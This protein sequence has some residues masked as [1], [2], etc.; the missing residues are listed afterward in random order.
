VASSTAGVLMIVGSALFFAG[1]AIA[2]PRVFTE[3]DRAEKA[4]LLAER[5]TAWRVGQPLYAVGALV[6]GLGVGVMEL[7]D[8][9][10]DTSWLAIAGTLLVIGALAWSLSVFRR[11][12]RPREF[13]LGELPGWP[14]FS[15][16]WLTFAGLALMGV[17]VLAG[18]WASWIGWMVLGADALFILAFVSL[19]DIPPFVFYVVLTIA[20]IFVL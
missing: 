18:G 17:G 10:A 20:G 7:D 3:P 16:V 14:Y 6:A 4:R 11:G 2:V 12:R 19:R 1:A 15:Y 13:A 9:A 8:R 5:P